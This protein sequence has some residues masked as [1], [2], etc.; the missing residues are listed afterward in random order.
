[1]LDAGRP[2]ARQDFLSDTVEGYQGVLAQ[3][4]GFDAVA[5]EGDKT[6]KAAGIILAAERFLR[7][8]LAGL[9]KA[10]LGFGGF[11]LGQI[12]DVLDESNLPLSARVIG[13]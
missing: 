3:V 13:L 7:I 9:V 8:G 4:C 2:H 5:H 10:A 1:M 11:A 6:F 12:N